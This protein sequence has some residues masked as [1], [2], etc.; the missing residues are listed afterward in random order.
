MKKKTKIAIIGL[1]YVGLPLAIEFGKFFD[2]V[3]YDIDVKRINSLKLYKD[4]NK[5]II[6]SE[7]IKSKKL[8]FTNQKKYLENC[9]FYIITVPTPIN[10]NNTPDLK[11]IK[12]AC[13]LVG[14]FI[15]KKSVVILEST[16]FPGLTKQIAIPIIEK[17]SKL[18]INKDFYFGYSPE[19]INPGDKKRKLINI[20]KIVSGSNKY[21]LNLIAEL[22]S[23]IIKA[24]VYK[25]QSIEIAEA[26]K[27]IENCQRDL[28]I[29]FVN[30]LSMIFDKM[31]LN[32]NQILKA[33]S[34]K[35]NFHK[36]T[37]GLVGGHCIGVD[38]YY[39]TYQ[40]KKYG[41]NPK[42][43]LSGRKVNNEMSEFVIKKTKEI[44]KSNNFVLNKSKVLLMGF[45][46]K[47]NCGDIRNTKIS[48]I[49]NK[50][51][52]IFK[53]VDIYDPMA[54]KKEVKKFY[55]L[56]LINSPKNNYYDLVVILVNHK[57]FYKQGI[58]NI[59]R[60][61]K[62]TSIIYDFKNIFNLNNNI[63]INNAKYT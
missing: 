29:A 12:N 17:K 1:G 18:K 48:E 27:V 3:G 59:N 54:N 42:M 56:K 19:R 33:A 61:L 6:K 50:S 31:N 5:D 8:F 47:E 41:Y 49:V 23:I 57:I 14:Q 38:P 53:L 11:L 63:I 52:K 13:S 22:Y 9:S 2:V 30:E 44:M 25:A 39:L 36:F 15:Q 58:K 51:K 32:T 55:N 7:F 10:I 43:I 4:I 16:V 46:F 24:G 37:P 40:S 35:W 26:A 62:K 20:I 28:N 34:T 60:F 45:T 21:S